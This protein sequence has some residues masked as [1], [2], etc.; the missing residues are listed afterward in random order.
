MLIHG[1]G[2]WSSHTVVSTLWWL[3]TLWRFTDSYS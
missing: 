3:W 2:K 1:F